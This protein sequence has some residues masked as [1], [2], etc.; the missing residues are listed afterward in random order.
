MLQIKLL[1]LDTP[2]MTEDS[3]QATQC[4]QFLGSSKSNLSS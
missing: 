1:L 4:K 2:V 3:E